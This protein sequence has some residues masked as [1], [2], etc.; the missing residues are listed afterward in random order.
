MR[1]KSRA[2]IKTLNRILLI[3]A[4]CY[5]IFTSLII[6]RVIYG[7]MPFYGGRWKLVWCDEF[8]GTALDLTKWTPVSQGSGPNNELQAYIDENVTV[9]NG[10]LVLGTKKEE[11][12]GPDN[13]R[14]G[15]AVT[16]Y[17]TSGRVNSKDKDAWTYGRFEIRAKFPAGQGLISYAALFP[18]DDSW[19]PEIEIVEMRGKDPRAVYLLNIWGSNEQQHDDNSGP[20]MGY[21]YSADFHIY[22][23]EWEPRKLRWYID[24]IEKFQLTQNIPDKPLYLRLLTS[25]GGIYGGDPY[26]KENKSGLS[27]PKYFFVD[28]VR[29]YQRR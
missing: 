3:L 2:D 21:D 25:V 23:L 26:N 24:G 16:R 5:A 27:L 15:E 14:T 17:F 28:W 7:T 12:T 10:C 4:I 13:L 29:V 20:V 18:I 1:P 11:W 9:K 19:P 8:N 22:T 6:Y